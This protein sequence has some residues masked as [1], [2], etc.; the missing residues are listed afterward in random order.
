[1]HVTLDG[2][3]SMVAAV[4]I[5]ATLDGRSTEGRGQVLGGPPTTFDVNLQPGDTGMLKLDIG[6]LDGTGCQ[7]GAGSSLLT[8]ADATSSSATIT[9]NYELQNQ[10]CRLTIANS[11][12]GTGKITD[13]SGSTLCN[14]STSATT[15]CADTYPL[16]SQLTL[17]ASALS[18]SYFA[19]WTG[20]CT[21]T[22]GCTVTI[23]ARPQI[24][25]A[26]LLPTKLC[27]G[28]I[29]WQHPLPQGG[30]LTAVSGNSSDD[31]WMVGEEGTILH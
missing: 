11:G 24:V 8:I 29:C 20:A 10:G 17:T 22:G 14:F 6:A 27:V 26:G 12:K 21:N 9:L 23:E 25:Y 31:I 13:A 16:G 7:L 2:L 19:G 28:S 15:E 5:T 3:T 30:T 1:V 4:S 18:G